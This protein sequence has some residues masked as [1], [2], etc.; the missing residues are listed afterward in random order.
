MGGEERGYANRI[1]V[2]LGQQGGGL[3]GIGEALER[4]AAYGEGIEASLVYMEKGIEAERENWGKREAIWRGEVDR[5]RQEGIEREKMLVGDIQQLQA[6]IDKLHRDR[7]PLVGGVRTDPVEEAL[8]PLRDYF[9][10]RMVEEKARRRVDVDRSWV[11][12]YLDATP[13]GTVEGATDALVSNEMVRDA[14]EAVALMAEGRE[15]VE[16]MRYFAYVGHREDWGVGL[17]RLQGLMVRLNDLEGR[18][19]DRGWHE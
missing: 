16:G 1:R 9:D 12:Q 7:E 14:H 4:V 3:E 17:A 10:Q 19:S 6:V 8:R 13:D 11:Q 2:L 18:M 15:C 5:E